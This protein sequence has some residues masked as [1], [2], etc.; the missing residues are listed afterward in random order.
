MVYTFNDT[1][2]RKD[3]WF[4]V[5]TYAAGIAGPWLLCGDFNCVL[6][7]TERLG[8]QTN[9]EEMEDFQSCIDHCTLI[10][11]PTAGSL[12]TWNNKQDPSTR[13]Y[14]RL[15]R[16]LVNQ[17]WLQA[18]PDAYANFYNE[19]YFDHSPCIIQDSNTS[20]V[21]R[22]SLK[23]FNM[24]SKVPEFLPCIQYKWSIQWQGTKMF[25]VVL[26]AIQT[27]LHLNPTDPSLIDQEREALTKSKA[28][29]VN[30]GDNNTNYFHSIL[31]NRNVK[32]KVFR[33]I[34]I[35]GHTHTDGDKIQHA[36]L[37]YY[38]QLSGTS[39]TTFPVSASVVQLGKVCNHEHWDTLLQPVSKSEVKNAI[40][41]IPNHKAPGPDGFL[42]AFFKESWSIIGDEVCSAVLDFFA[43][44]KLLQ[45]VD[46][47]K[48]YDSVN[49]DFL[50]QM[51]YALHFPPTFIHLVMTCVRTA[52][53]SLVLNGV[54]FGY[55][56]G[57]KATG[58]Q[59]NSMKS[60]IYFNGVQN[61]V[62]ADI[63]EVFGF[64]EGTL[65]F[66]YL[67]VPIVADRLTL[68]HCT[69][70]I[71]KVISR[72]R[73]FGVRKLSYSGRLTLV[74]AVLTSLSP[75]VSCDKLCVPK[76]EGGLG[77]SNNYYWNAAAIGKLAWW[78]HS[79]PDALWVRWI[80]HVYIKG[81][82]WPS[83]SP[84]PDVA[85]SWKTICKIKNK[86]SLGFNAGVWTANPAGYSV[87]S[88]YHCIRQHYPMV[89]W[90]KYI[91]N[92]CFNTPKEFWG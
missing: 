6:T 37:S 36:F 79:K 14:S 53:Y 31:K 49:W 8:G 59:M 11:S 3:L 66:K 25:K 35:D 9:I 74:N 52:S 28:T 42:S 65:P 57:A 13:V 61:S 4:D 54:N 39:S 20:F 77:V 29:W 83:Y 80:N 70:L 26:D 50:E 43:T 12:Y 78:I 16:V 84:K 5:S 82:A 62:K 60:N 87:S 73:G 44:G 33:I 19:G 68:K 76:C 1:L 46:L 58:L 27:A 10:D 15:D 48:A 17:E 55:F 69:V 56:K 51:L 89:T 91:W 92:S 2:T 75:P 41:S 7:L 81:A 64:V 47:K 21:G 40:F 88:G 34:D 45:Q 63:I 72:I 86:F 30:K 71:D 32:T 22:K 90:Y 24:W 38:H 67:G 18:R 23:F 85:W